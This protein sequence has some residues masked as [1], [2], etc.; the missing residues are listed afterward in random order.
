MEV[1]DFCLLFQIVNKMGCFTQKKHELNIEENIF[2][3]HWTST[4]WGQQNQMGMAR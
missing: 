4:T 2:I 3:T 1:N